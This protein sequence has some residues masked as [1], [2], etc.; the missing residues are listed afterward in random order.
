MKSAFELALERSG[1]QLSEIPEE[2]KS[3]LNDIDLKYKAKQ[4]E[5]HLSADRRLA[6]E[7][8]PEK[9]REIRESLAAEL[10][11]LRERA[12]RE[13]EAVRKG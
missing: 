10:A 7:Q 13:K 3:R 9:I 2:M 6:E 1:G 12:E 5:A 8:D 4:A 11:S